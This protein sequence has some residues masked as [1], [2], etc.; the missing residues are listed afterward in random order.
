M[1]WQPALLIAFFLVARDKPPEKRT[2]SGSVVSS[3]TD[4]S[5]YHGEI[6]A[7]P[8]G[9]GAASTTVTDSKGNFTPVDLVPGQY[10]LKGRRNGYPS[11]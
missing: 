1:P 3:A 11:T 6:F 8:V 4:D 9:A 10:R 2:L 7:E 5:L